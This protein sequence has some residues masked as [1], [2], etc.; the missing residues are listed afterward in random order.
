MSEAE[1][2]KDS[3][4]HSCQF[5]LRQLFLIDPCVVLPHDAGL[6]LAVELL[7]DSGVLMVEGLV[8]LKQLGKEDIAVL[9]CLSIL[10]VA[11][12][13]SLRLDVVAHDGLSVSWLT[14]AGWFQW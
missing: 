2:C 5:G 12:F 3:R 13:E 1:G 11:G 4:T 7:L 14:G 8:A 10:C 6:L 9:V